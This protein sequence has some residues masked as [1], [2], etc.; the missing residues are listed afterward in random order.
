MAT[1]TSVETALSQ[2]TEKPAYFADCC[3]AISRPL[4][5]TIIHLLPPPPTCVLSIGSGS[6]L[7]EAMILQVTAGH[8][9]ELFGVEVPSCVNK[10]LPEQHVLR[11]PSTTS[12]HSDAILAQTLLFVYPRKVSLIEDYLKTFRT[13]ML[14]QVIWYGQKNDWPE[15]N[16]LLSL[17]FHRVCVIDTVGVADHELLAMASKTVNGKS[18]TGTPHKRDMSP[19]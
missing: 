5:H 11:V 15:A 6:G 19:G 10:F 7:L 18:A 17:F 16:D 13:G 1:S 4:I 12:L 3:A 8:Q 14:A 2:L 9:V